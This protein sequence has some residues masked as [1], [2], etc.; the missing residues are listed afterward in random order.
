M[1]QLHTSSPV[2]SGPEL[3]PLAVADIEAF[4]AFVQETARQRGGATKLTS[5][6]KLILSDYIYYKWKQNKELEEGAAEATP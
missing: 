2:V 3:L 5:T 4:E 1:I 6:E